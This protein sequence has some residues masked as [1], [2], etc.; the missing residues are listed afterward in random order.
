MYV[1][2]LIF[3]EGMDKSLVCMYFCVCIFICQQAKWHINN[4]V[5]GLDRNAQGHWQ[6]CW[7]DH[8]TKNEN[9]STV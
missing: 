2:M 1:G 6:L 4:T 5:R 8:K 7:T 3:G 9:K